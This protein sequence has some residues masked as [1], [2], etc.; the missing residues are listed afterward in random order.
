VVDVECVAPDN[1]R[2]GRG[3]SARSFCDADGVLPGAASEVIKR[4]RRPLRQ[5]T[6]Q[7]GLKRR[8]LRLK[9]NARG[10]QLLQQQESLP[11]VVRVTTEHGGASIARETLVRF[12]RKLAGRR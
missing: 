2:T 12:I 10:R 1:V 6:D 5:P 4:V 7:S 11:V 8:T 9:L 3:K